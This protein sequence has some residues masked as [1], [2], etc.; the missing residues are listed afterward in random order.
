MEDDIHFIHAPRRPSSTTTSTSWHMCSALADI[1]GEIAAVPQNGDIAQNHRS[2]RVA[3]ADGSIQ[4]C[5]GGIDVDHLLGYLRVELPKYFCTSF[6]TSLPAEYKL[7][8][9]SDL[10]DSFQNLR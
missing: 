2:A 4:Q 1:H 8:N 3:M 7:F 6:L 5:R 10:Q 9:L